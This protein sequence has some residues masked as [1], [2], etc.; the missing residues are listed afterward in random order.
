MKTLKDYIVT[1]NNFFKNLGIGQESQIRKWLKEHK[2]K[3]YIINKDLTIN[4]SDDTFLYLR[5][6]EKYLPDYIQFNHCDDSFNISGK[7]LK[8][9][10]GCPKDISYPGGFG[11]NNCES[12]TSLDGCP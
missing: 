4:L 12:L 1:E 5:D 6:D 8:S 10:R 9:L 7:N 11:C 2:I 3:N